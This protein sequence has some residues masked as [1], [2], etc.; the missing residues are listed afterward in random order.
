M[1]R[2]TVSRQGSDWFL[3]ASSFVGNGGGTEFRIDKSVALGADNPCDDKGSP[4][5]FQ[6]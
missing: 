4:P 5:D 6:G 1:R 2:R 3:S